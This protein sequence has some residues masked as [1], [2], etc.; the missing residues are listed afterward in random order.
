MAAVLPFTV[1]NAII[2]CE[3]D[4]V[5]H[6]EGQTQAQRI[7]RDVF[8]DDFDT[9]LVKTIEDFDDDLKHYSDL[10]ANSGRIRLN[11]RQKKNI[12]ALMFW[13]YDKLRIGQNPAVQAFP[14]AQAANIIRKSKDNKAFIDKAKTMAETAKPEQFTEKVKWADWFPTFINFLNAIPGRH[15]LPLGYV[16]RENENPQ[17]VE[18]LTW[19]SSQTSLKWQGLK[20][21]PF[22]VTLL[23]Y[24][25]ISCVLLL[26]IQ[27]QKQKFYLT[28][29]KEMGVR[30]SLPS[31]IIMLA[32]AF[33][34]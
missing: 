16:C 24:T 27:L 5:T 31:K 10:P 32:L 15:G 7:S 8:D 11:P 34:Q 2:L 28:L 18:A 4:N 3:V 33:I 19:M 12:K 6:F 25:R 17:L 20:E 13:A 26:A 29:I 1:L 23:K 9:C 30:I 22:N 14:V 21:T